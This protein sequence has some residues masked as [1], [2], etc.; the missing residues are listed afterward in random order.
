MRWFRW[1]QVWAAFGLL[2]VVCVLTL[3]DSIIGPLTGAIGDGLD[4]V[5]GLKP[6]TGLNVVSRPDL[7]LASDT[8]GHFMAWTAVGLTA[9]GLVVTT[10]NRVNLF[11][12]LFAFSALLEVGQ[13]HLSWSR[14]AEFTDLVA[15]GVGL[16]LGFGMYALAETMLNA[17]I[18][19]LGTRAGGLLRRAV[20][21]S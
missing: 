1:M 4:V 11:L 5:R 3:S 10:I 20:P 17:A 12:G 15:N 18:P 6:G 9:G 2:A 8:I 7:P 21:R 13:R 14:S 16:A 19:A